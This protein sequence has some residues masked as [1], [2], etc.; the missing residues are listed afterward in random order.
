MPR[1]CLWPLA[2]HLI[3]G[4]GA[5]VLV[6][7]MPVRLFEAPRPRP[8][9]SGP[10]VVGAVLPTARVEADRVS[11]PISTAGGPGMLA[12]WWRILLQVQ[13]RRRSFAGCPVRLFEATRRVQWRVTPRL[14]ALRCP[15]PACRLIGSPVRSARQAGR[16]CWP[17]WRTQAGVPRA[18]L[19][20]YSLVNGWQG[21][22]TLPIS[23]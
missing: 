3:A 7:R 15:Q 20:L 17:W 5:A 13:A 10:E 22:S 8:V 16:R 9:A 1:P 14:L 21:C 2:A 6:R 4:S 12:P 18:A 23:L 11:S 19:R